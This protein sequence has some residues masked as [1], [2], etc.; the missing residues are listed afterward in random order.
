MWKLKSENKIENIGLIKEK[1]ESLKSKITC[2]Q[3][4]EVGVSNEITDTVNVYDVVLVSSFEDNIALQKYQQDP[5]HVKVA[6]FIKSVVTARAV[7]DYEV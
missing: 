4:F 5:E 1:L 3:D 2:I 6:E 7:V